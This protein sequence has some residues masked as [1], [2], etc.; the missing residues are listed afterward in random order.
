[1]VSATVK[2]KVAERNVTFNLDTVIKLGDDKFATTLKEYWKH[3][4]RCDCV[5]TGE[6]QSMNKEDHLDEGQE[7]FMHLVG[8][9]STDS[10]SVP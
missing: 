8:D 6:D 7:I 9:G 10:V 1:L 2:N 3:M 5:Q 4:S